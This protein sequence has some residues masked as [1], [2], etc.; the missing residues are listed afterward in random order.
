L[1]GGCPGGT[2]EAVNIRRAGMGD[3][4]GIGLVYVRSWQAAYKDPVPQHYLDGL[5]PGRRGQVWVRHL[6]EGHQVGEA[7]L[8]AEADDEVVGF[9]SVGP[10]RD[11][12]ANGQREV[13]AIYLLP[14]FWG[15][16]ARRVLMGAGAESLRG[17]GSQRRSSGC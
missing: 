8:V 16:G 4:V 17:S 1:E 2:I 13:W 5:D 10:S 7:V 14:D 6:S 12:D 11:K 9:V 3:S 15:Q